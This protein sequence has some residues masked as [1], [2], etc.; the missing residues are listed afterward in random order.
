MT[1]IGKFAQL[2]RSGNPR[3]FIEFLEFADRMPKTPEIRDHSFRQMR[4][5]PG[6]RVLDVG[7]GIGTAAREM[8]DRV[9]PQ[10]MVCGVDISETMLAEASMRMKDRTNIEFSS[11]GA[12][13]LPYPDAM[14]D[15]VRMERVLLYVPDRQKAVAE[16]MR[17]TKPGGRVVITD[18]DIDATAIAGKDRALTRKMTLL[19]AESFVHPNSARE[20][21]ALVRASG[22]KDVA[23]EFFVSPTPYEFCLF[24]TQG[25]LRAAADAGKTTTAELDEWYRG[26]AEVEQ[27]GG[28]VQLWFF[29]TVSGTVPG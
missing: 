22:L 6:S 17:V 28:F 16:M 10:G 14:F 15:A 23:T 5:Q 27:T 3:Y 18:V 26:L 9:G 13:E 19:L 7:C 29:A 4:I 2:D 11:G 8:S 25:V 1:Q 24:M 12:C 20:L 21:P